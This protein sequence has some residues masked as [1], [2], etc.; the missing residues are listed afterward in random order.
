SGL[1]DVYR[2]V[3]TLIRQ[4]DPLPIFYK[5]RSM[6]T[7]EEVGLIKMTTTG[8]NSAMIAAP[9][10]GFDENSSHSNNFSQNRGGKKGGNRSNNNKSR[11]NSAGGG[12]GGGG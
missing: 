8:S 7:L 11:N 1:T 5:A 2:G 10:K 4:S 9:S 3:G 6:L 12:H